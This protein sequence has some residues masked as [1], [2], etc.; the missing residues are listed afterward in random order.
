MTKIKKITVSNLKALSSLTADF[1]GC[2][3]IITGRNNSGKTSFLRALSDRLKSIKAPVLKQGEKEGFYEME[4]TSGEKLVWTFDTK[5]EKLTLITEKNIKTSITKEI[6]QTYF[7]K[8]FDVDKFL[9]DEPSKQKAAIEKIAGID[10]TEL[11]KAHSAAYEER[12]W[13]KRVLDET[14]A[15]KIDFEPEWVNEERSTE[16]LEAELNGLEAHNL[17]WKSIQEKLFLKVKQREKNLQEIQELEKKIS[18][19]KDENFLIDEDEKKGNTWLTEEKNMLKS[20]ETALLLKE[21]IQVFKDNNAAIKSQA[22]Y[23]KA[24]KNYVDADKEVKRIEADK[25]D[26]VKNSS[27]PEGFAFD[28][29]KV[30]YEGVPFNKQSL[31]SSGIY[32]AALKLAT[33]GLGEVRAL[34]FDASYLD[35]NSLKEIEVWADKNKLQLLIERPDFEAGEIEYQIIQDAKESV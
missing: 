14:E 29:D 33:V 20:A 1:N 32:I 23:D 35:K 17:R 2:T 13:C 3:A 30:T 27:L 9:T 16:L 4:L 22:A 24:L 15:K 34:H 7:P 6:G 26:A 18:Q 8:V 5:K 12:T 28:G 19:L 25:F 31:S 21:K 11:N 10:F